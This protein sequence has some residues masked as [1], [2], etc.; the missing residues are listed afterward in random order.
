MES[1]C[2]TLKSYALQ[3]CQQ[4]KQGMMQMNTKIDTS[5]KDIFSAIDRNSMHIPT[6]ISVPN[7]FYQQLLDYFLERGYL[8][9]LSEREKFVDF[10]A[11]NVAERRNITWLKVVRLPIHPNEMKEYDMLSR[12]QSVLSTLHT[13]GHR[14]VFLLQRKDG[15]TS[16]YLG[17]TSLDRDTNA[18][19]AL[20]QFKEAAMSGMPGIDL[21]PL[22]TKQEQMDFAMTLSDNSAIGAVTGIPSIRKNTQFGILQTLDQL[23]FGIRDIN[24][25]ERDFSLMVVADPVEDEEIA[26]AISNFRKLGSEIHLDVLKS[27]TDSE[28]LSEAKGSTIGIGAIAGALGSLLGLGG[29]STVLSAVGGIFNKTITK[30]AGASKAVLTQYLDKFAQYAEQLTEKHCARLSKGRNLGFWN[31]GIYVLGKSNKD[32][33][34]VM[35]ML[36]AIY[37]GDESFVEPIRVHIL[38]DTSGALDIVR[39]CDLIPLISDR[40]TPDEI[41]GDWNILGKM[42][43]YVSTPLNTEELS[44]ATSL[45]RRD[46]PGLRFVKTSV[47]FANNP[48]PSKGDTI[49]LGKVV[50]TGV[51]QNN[52]YRIDPDAL[53]RH[54]IVTG[55]TGS[56]KSTTCKNI[57]KEVMQRDIPVLIIEPAKD[58]Y[59]RWAMEYNRALE[60]DDSLTEEEK[61]KKRFQIYMP[62]VERIDGVLVNRLKL[63][64][65]Q[66]AAIKDAPVDMMTRCEQVTALFNASLPTADVLPVLIDE[67]LYR[68]V[69]EQ[70][71]EP[72]LSGDMPQKKEYPRLDG[73]IQTAK[74][75]LAARGYDKKVQDDIRAA[76]E[77]RF[78]YLTRGKRGN[79]LNV[80]SSTDF[81]TLFS[82]PTVI[83]VS[84]IAGVKDKS[85]IMS[86]LMLAIYEY[87]VSAYTYNEEYRSNAQK[88][89]LLHLTVVEEAHNLLMKPMFD[90]SNSGNPQQVV[91]DLFSNLLSEIRSYGQG[92]MIVDQIP[93]RLV[94]DAI[95]NT[96]YKIVHRLTAP[97]DCLT[98]A[99][100]LALRQDQSMVIPALSVGDAIVCGDLD[101]AAAWVRMRK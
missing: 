41:E 49:C 92:I 101:D 55:S 90:N 56:G 99:S 8:N 63:N 52:E 16:L 79:I 71:G 35:G 34:T 82:R 38:Q 39:R 19:Q 44:I 2:R 87:R 28:N 30:T 31:V 40:L 78:S 81:D 27:V 88:N 84:K 6:D 68:Y 80:N 10:S 1:A 32:I 13:W 76:L 48:A 74:N 25:T 26:R 9:S 22:L 61:E 77:T 23:A 24:G 36:R 59:V 45:P 93:T 14:L 50:D 95:K 85:L 18:K 42:F 67:A 29:L 5:I 4:E 62:G 33:N 64:P 47:R 21:H 66:P 54:A 100:G 60:A 51:V 69:H 12:W 3:L 91:A 83:N 65:F 7:N 89:K 96:N 17:T 86:I 57:I 46:V 72:F 70:V 97:D 15:E 37:S 94:A 58:D 73:V 20:E 53:V 98:M 75:V 11:L 43:Q